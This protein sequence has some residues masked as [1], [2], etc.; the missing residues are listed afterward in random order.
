MAIVPP[1][2]MASDRGKAGNVTASTLVMNPASRSPGIGGTNART[3]VAKVTASAANR[4]DD[5]IDA[6]DHSR[7][8]DVDI[9]DRY[10]EPAGG[11]GLMERV[12]RANERL[13]GIAAGVEAGAADFPLLD[14][15]HARTLHACLGRGGAPGGASADDDQIVWCAGTASHRISLLLSYCGKTCRG[16]WSRGEDG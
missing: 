6:V 3:P 5:A 16:F 13:R 10:P 7:P 9:L 14:H 11:A 4:V 1:P 15:G 8:I 2:M 12:S